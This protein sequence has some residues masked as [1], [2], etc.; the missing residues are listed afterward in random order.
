MASSVTD[1][2]ALMKDLLDTLKVLQVNQVQLAS[3]VDAINGRVN[4]L[5]G[6]KEVQD[7]A[8]V[9]GKQED[10]LAIQNPESHDDDDDVPKSPSVT[11][12]DTGTPSTLSVSNQPNAVTSRI[13]LT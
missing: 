13:I 9:H 8:V 6:I 11:P 7:A 4:I 1:Q 10:G 3:T 12:T 5:A 2:T